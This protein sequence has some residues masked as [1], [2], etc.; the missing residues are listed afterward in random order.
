MPPAK[1]PRRM[2]IAPSPCF[3]NTTVKGHRA[4]AC[5]R[6]RTQR[7]FDYDIREPFA[8][9]PISS[10]HPLGVA[11]PVSSRKRARRW[12]RSG[13]RTTATTAPVPSVPRP[14]RPAFGESTGRR[15]APDA[16]HH[17]R[18]R[19]VARRAR[20]GVATPDRG[21]IAAGTSSSTSLRRRFDATAPPASAW[22][23]WLGCPVRLTLEPE[24]AASWRIPS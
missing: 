15:E 24:A 22:A 2:P 3:E 13:M 12:C 5:G 1:L 20:R 9:C 19:A 8:D 4:S 10:F 6:V 21:P 11:R 17:A 16:E 14:P 23:R 7:Q 18:L